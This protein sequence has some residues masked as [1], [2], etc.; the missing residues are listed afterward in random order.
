MY[1]SYFAFLDHFLLFSHSPSI[2]YPTF[3]DL[4]HSSSSLCPYFSYL[5]FLMSISLPLLSCSISLITTF[6]LPIL[7]I[8]IPE[9]LLSEEFCI[10]TVHTYMYSTES[11]LDAVF[12]FLLTLVGSHHQ[13]LISLMMWSFVFLENKLFKATYLKEKTLGFEAMTRQVCFTGP[14]NS[15]VVKWSR[16]IILEVL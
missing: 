2:L 16:I 6:R 7:L 8:G 5:V 12:F 3:L 9:A 1:I 11:W 15:S 4:S 10:Y 13:K 14:Y